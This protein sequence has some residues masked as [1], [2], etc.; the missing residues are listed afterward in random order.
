MNTRPFSEIRTAADTISFR[1]LR[2]RAKRSTGQE[3]YFEQNHPHPD[4]LPSDGRGNRQPRLSQLPKRLDTPTDGGRFS[5]S[6]PMGYLL[7]VLCAA[8][9]PPADRSVT[10][11]LILPARCRQHAPARDDSGLLFAKETRPNGF[12]LDVPL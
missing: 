3:A 8:G 9:V 2:V 11:R 7:A 4:P 10:H 6:H 1:L 5:L 12:G